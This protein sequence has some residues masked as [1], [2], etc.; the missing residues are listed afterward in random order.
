MFV[1]SDFDALR[2]QGFEN[3]LPFGEFTNISNINPKGSQIYDHIWIT[4]ST[5]MIS[6]G[7]LM[8]IL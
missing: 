2:K 4:N 6:S 3:C 1:I 5:K 8:N 7:M